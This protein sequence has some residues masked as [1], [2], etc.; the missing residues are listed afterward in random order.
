MRKYNRRTF[1][2]NSLGAIAAT[3]C[4]PAFGKTPEAGLTATTV[5]TLGKT[6]LTCSL[7]GVGT[8]TK[9]RDGTTDQTRMPHADLVKLLEYAYGCGITYFDLADRYGSHSH[10]KEA[11][12]TIPR[13]KVMLLTKAW[14]RE[15]EKIKADIERFRKELNTDYLDIVLMHCLRKGEEDWPN[16]LKPSMDVLAEAKAKGLIRAHGVSCHTLES[17]RRTADTEWAD[18]VLARINPFGANMDGPVDDVVSILK[19]LHD[20]GKGILGMK[21]LGEGKPEVTAKMAESLEFV[22]G[23]GSVDA[24]TI[25]FMNAAQLDEVMTRIEEVGRA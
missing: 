7:L 13:E 16:T 17:L 21:I 10:M 12:E 2:K 25:G 1:L 3:A 5:R 9:G 8:G 18:V 11:L 15:P 14:D 24:M 23:L 4:L 20:A 19:K 6:G 22:L